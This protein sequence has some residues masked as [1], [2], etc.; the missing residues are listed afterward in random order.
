MKHIKITVKTPKNQ[1][2]KC[3]KSQRDQLLGI[4]KSN[5]VTEAKLIAHNKFYW[6][7]PYK[8][9]E[10]LDKITKR[11]A[12]GETMIKAF[13]NKL[14]KAIKWV[15]KISNKTGK[16]GEYLRRQFIRYFKKRYSMDDQEGFKEYINGQVI[17]ESISIDD[18]AEIKK[19]LTNPLFIVKEQHNYQ[20]PQP[21][22]SKPSTP[23]KQ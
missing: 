19:L 13:Y 1:A 23:A 2:A 14:F 9:A 20:E 4:K 7:L 6:I 3:I 15:N 16:T 8:D 12:L 21:D 11:L 17:N 18:E 5:A 22:Q 10:E